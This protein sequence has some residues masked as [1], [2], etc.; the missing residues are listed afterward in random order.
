MTNW[1]LCLLFAG[2]STFLLCR[3]VWAVSNHELFASFDRFIC[4]ASDFLRLLAVVVV[5]VEKEVKKK[6]ICLFV[7]IHKIEMRRRNHRNLILASLRLFYSP[8]FKAIQHE[9]I[10]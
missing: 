3:H 4:F 8:S 2:S 5:D 10:Y 1:C 9:I 6:K 7:L